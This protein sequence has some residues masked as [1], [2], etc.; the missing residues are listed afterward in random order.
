M[1]PGIN[2]RKMQQMMKQMGIKQVELDAISVII[3]TSDSEIV[4]DRPQVSKVNM[5]GQETYQIVGTPEVRELVTF[6]VN[7]DDINAVVEQTGKS[8]E[9]A[10]R[11]LED[12]E[13]DLAEAI[14][15]LKG[16]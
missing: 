9:E 7:E 11:A 2:P 14:M 3:R 10:R 4:F 16:E 5:M 12:S 13:G 8:K 6:S 15:K 1:F